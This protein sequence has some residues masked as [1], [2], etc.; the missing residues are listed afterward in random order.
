M[1]I[2]GL[3][4]TKLQANQAL[5]DSVVD[6]V[7]TQVANATNVSKAN[8]EVTLSSG[9]VVANVTISASDVGTVESSL[10]SQMPSLKTNVVSTLQ[11]LSGIVNVTYDSMA[12]SDVSTG[13]TA[14]T[15][16]VTT[17]NSP[18]TK[19]MDST[20]NALTSSTTIAPTGSTNA[21]T[22]S[23]TIAPT[24]IPAQGNTTTRPPNGTT[25]VEE[26]RQQEASYSRMLRTLSKPVMTIVS[27]SFAVA[28]LGA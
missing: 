9:S 4:Y 23:G 1:R 2:T 20:T 3:N 21:V 17:T 16:T 24:T 8:I 26:L 12:V 25:S 18:T 28:S 27:L 6:G 7:K 19:P 14:S 10:S 15:T 5:F 11:G 13:I 22:S